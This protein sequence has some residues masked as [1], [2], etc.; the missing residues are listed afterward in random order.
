MPAGKITIEAY[1]NDDGQI[2]YGVD[3]GIGGSYVGSLSGY[4][5]K[6]IDKLYF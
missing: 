6:D 3:F 1:A 5:S 4:S 2:G